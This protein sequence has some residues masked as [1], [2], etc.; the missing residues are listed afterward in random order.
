[1]LMQH[2][3]HSLWLFIQTPLFALTFILALCLYFVVVYIVWAFIAGFRNQLK[4][5][6]EDKEVEQ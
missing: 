2:L 5:P 1:M 4:K 6:D 3:W